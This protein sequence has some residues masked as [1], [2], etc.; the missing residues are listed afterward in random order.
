[1]LIWKLFSYCHWWVE[2]AIGACPFIPTHCHRK[3][4]VIDKSSC[5]AFFLAF[6]FVK[7]KDENLFFSLAFYRILTF[8]VLACFCFKMSISL[9]QVYCGIAILTEWKPSLNKLVGNERL[10]TSV[11]FNGS[12]VFGPHLSLFYRID[13]KISCN[14]GSCDSFIVIIGY[15][16]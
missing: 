16:N 8:K 5:R 4:Q 2:N 6:K 1:M 14:K 15:L 10:K 9:A 12:S 3:L 11:W 7:D 13:E